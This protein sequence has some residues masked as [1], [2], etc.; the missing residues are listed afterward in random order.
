MLY[1]VITANNLPN[2]TIEKLKGEVVKEYT[3]YTGKPLD[4][5]AIHTKVIKRKVR[6][7]TKSKMALS[8]EKMTFISYNFV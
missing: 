5:K 3:L 1:E 4:T 8:A 6:K 7:E 2:P